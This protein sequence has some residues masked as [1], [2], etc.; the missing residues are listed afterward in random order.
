[1]DGD[2]TPGTEE[3]KLQGSKFEENGATKM[4]R[5]RKESL[6]NS[7]FVFKDSTNFHQYL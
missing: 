6:A 5:K 4:L 1:M 3:G 2:G 7:A